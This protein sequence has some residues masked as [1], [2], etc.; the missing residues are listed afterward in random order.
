MKQLLTLLAIALL[1]TIP[2]K[3]QNNTE[4][5]IRYETF[6]K[7]DIKIIGNNTL[8]R[9][10]KG[11]S[12]NVPYNDR[13]QKAKLNDEFDMQY[14]DIDNDPTTFSSS[15]AN[16]SFDGTGGKVAY[17]G[18][19]WSATYPYNSGVLRG[20][21]NVATDA[22][23]DNASM[24]K[25]KTPDSNSYVT[26][27]GELIFDGI[28]DP[29]L[30]NSAPYVYYAN[31]TTLLAN[32]NHVTGDYTV[33]N[34]KA[35]LGQVEGGSTAGWALVIVYENPDSNVKKIITYDG[36]SAITNEASKTF[37]F[38]GFKTP[39]EGDFKT[40]IMGVTL[41]GDF[42]M[43]G[44]NVSITIPESGKTVSLESKLRPAQNFFNSTININDDFV[45][46]RTPASENTL[47][48]DIFRLDIK[49][50]NQELI[51]NNAT[52]LDLNYT[53]S[54]DRYY[55]YLTALEIENNPKEITQLYRSTRVTKLTAKDT[56]KGYYVIVGVFLNINNVEKRV[57]E[58][59]NWGYE[60]KVY[61][62]KDQVL[63]FIYVDR[64]D[65]YEDAMKKVDEIR[66]NTEIPDPWILD[67]AN[68]E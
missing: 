31:V 42:N 64:F 56:E 54:R 7:G 8:N 1:V 34:V 21:K 22:T 51:P 20:T 2:L 11:A 26:V 50:P 44:D 41:E 46:G 3:A 29:Q 39:E 9:K 65:K 58:M 62:N 24:V 53:R 36:F 19:Y 60:A 28:N 52:S 30:K 55:L 18:L 66:Q 48:F 68:Y 25:L 49:N 33:A 15:S 57:E 61:Y 5:K 45:T 12:P 67:V 16:F 23:R 37:S 32:S 17:A 13:T 40:R 47:G 35:A 63:N 4:F 43:M 14:I 38:K 27:D 6:I 59:K 10:E